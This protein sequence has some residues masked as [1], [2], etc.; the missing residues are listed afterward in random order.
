MAEEN[1]QLLAR[2]GSLYYGHDPGGVCMGHTIYEVIN[3]V[4]PNFQAHVVV[5]Q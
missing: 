1:H 2:V 5:V 3:A 4:A